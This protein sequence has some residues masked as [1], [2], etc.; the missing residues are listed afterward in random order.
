[1][2]KRWREPLGDGREFQVGE[3]LAQLLVDVVGHR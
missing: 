2:L 3:V 1:V